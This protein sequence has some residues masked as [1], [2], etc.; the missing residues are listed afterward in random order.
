MNSHCYASN[1]IDFHNGSHALYKG[2]PISFPHRPNLF[3]GPL[4]AV[5]C[6]D[7]VV[8]T[9]IIFSVINQQCDLFSV[10]YDLNN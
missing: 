4:K 7:A 5:L 3:T 9:V 6:A 8:A 2:S 1:M 10:L